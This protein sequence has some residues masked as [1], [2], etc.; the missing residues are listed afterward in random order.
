[1]ILISKSAIFKD[2]VSKPKD[3]KLEIIFIY[4][5]QHNVETRHALSLCLCAL[6]LEFII[7]HS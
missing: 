4:Q 2:T 6:A 1:M 3:I 5:Q 7:H